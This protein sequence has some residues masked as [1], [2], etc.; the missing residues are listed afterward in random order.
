M[1][2]KFENIFVRNLLLHKLGSPPNP[3]KTANPEKNDAGHACE[4]VSS[5]ISST[6]KQLNSLGLVGMVEIGLL[7]T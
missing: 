5:T 2:I 6:P 1:A 3:K 4:M 7:I